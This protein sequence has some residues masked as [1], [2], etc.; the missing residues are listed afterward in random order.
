MSPTQAGSRWPDWWEWGLEFTPHLEKRME[1]RDFTEIELR[2]MLTHARSY[3][4]DVVEGRWVIETFHRGHGWQVIV[5]PDE[6]EYLLVV[7]TAYPVEA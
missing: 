2:E 5:E 1:D 3:Q 6:V 7:V 4:P